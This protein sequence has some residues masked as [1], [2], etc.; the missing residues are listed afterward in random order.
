MGPFITSFDYLAAR[1]INFQRPVLMISGAICPVFPPPLYFHSRSLRT[2]LNSNFSQCNFKIRV[3]LFNPSDV[4]FPVRG[5][6]ETKTGAL[7][8]IRKINI[9]NCI[10]GTMA[11]RHA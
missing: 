4:S 7:A 10:S 5:R 1:D 11:D 2:L 9:H 8:R 3:N 6:R